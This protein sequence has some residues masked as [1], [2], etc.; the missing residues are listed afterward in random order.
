MKNNMEFMS[1]TLQDQPFNFQIP[2]PFPAV[3]K[4][5]LEVALHL[6][7]L[8]RNTQCRLDDLLQPGLERLGYSRQRKD[9]QIWAP[10]FDHCFDFINPKKGIAI[11]IE[12]SEVKRIVHDVLKFVKGSRLTKKKIRYGVLVIPNRYKSAKSNHERAFWEIVQ[13]DVV[14][15]CKDIILESDLKDILFLV[16]DV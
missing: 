9:C 11:E 8:T 7:E 4:Q 15:Y 13:Q 1:Y 12:K 2:E 16:Y 5:Q 10:E 6:V 3:E 14:F